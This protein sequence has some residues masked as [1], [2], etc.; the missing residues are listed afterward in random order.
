MIVT[1]HVHVQSLFTSFFYP[2]INLFHSAVR[3]WTVADVT[4]AKRT[5][6]TSRPAVEV[7]DGEG[8]G[9][10]GLSSDG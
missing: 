3:M 8:E 10:A 5:L 9:C 1:D 4:G 6:T 7:G 2:L